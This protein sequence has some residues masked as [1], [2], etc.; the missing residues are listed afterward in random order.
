[1]ARPVIY[2]QPIDVLS[3]SIAGVTIDVS[4]RPVTFM[5]S[6]SHTGRLWF[7]CGT[8]KT[9][10]A[11]EGADRGWS[12]SRPMELVFAQ[13]EAVDAHDATLAQ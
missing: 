5:E 4:D 10:N 9:A 7:I 11:G 12:G 3:L 6:R 8:R 2:G 1:M 13:D